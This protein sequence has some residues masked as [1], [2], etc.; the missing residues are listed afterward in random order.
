MLTSFPLGS[1]LVIRLV[2]V[3]SLSALFFH[4]VI[5]TKVPLAIKN[6]GIQWGIQKRITSPCQHSKKASRAAFQAHLIVE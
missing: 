3:W 6:S 1:L 5:T 2:I 4:R